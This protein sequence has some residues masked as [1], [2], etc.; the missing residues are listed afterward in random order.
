MIV[1]YHSLLHQKRWTV[2]EFT[3]NNDET[4]S[5]EDRS[6]RNIFCR[7]WLSLAALSSLRS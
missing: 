1:A 4:A 2:R 5:N 6:S 7:S 3:G